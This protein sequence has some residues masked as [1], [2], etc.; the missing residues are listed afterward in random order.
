VLEPE[1]TKLKPTGLEMGNLNDKPK[2]QD[3]ELTR[4]PVRVP[5]P[6][7]VH[8]L[9][10]E[11]QAAESDSRKPRPDQEIPGPARR[12]GTPIPDS[13][14]NLLNR[15]S[16]DFPIPGQ[17]GNRGFPPRFPAKNR[18]SG[19]IRGIRFPIPE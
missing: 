1:L 12:I 15:E 17:I 3:S 19:P 7:R 14:P 4:Q 8:A 9:P 18:E 5:G 2:V 11:P 16:G 6:A 13:R 10:S